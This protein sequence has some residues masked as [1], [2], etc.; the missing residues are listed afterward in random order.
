MGKKQK[1][2]K[3]CLQTTLTPKWSKPVINGQND[4]K[5]RIYLCILHYK[6][7]LF[8]MDRKEKLSKTCEKTVFKVNQTIDMNS[9]QRL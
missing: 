1:P 6:L 3:T 5:E 9:E 8:Q 4:V 2:S 7:V